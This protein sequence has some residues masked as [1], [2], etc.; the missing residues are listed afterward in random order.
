MAGVEVTAAVEEWRGEPTR[1][2]E[3]VPV[4]VTVD[5][6]SGESIRLRYEDFALRSPSGERF[7]AL[8]PF[9]IDARQA[10]PI[11]YAYPYD[12]FYVAPHLRSFF[13]YMSPYHGHF[14]H[15]RAF[16]HSY[17]PRFVRYELPTADMVQKALPEGVL[18]PGGKVTG[19]LYFDE[20]VED[21]DL[22]EE[23][24]RVTFEADL[25]DAVTAAHVATIEIPLKLG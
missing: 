5:N 1:L 17:H 14:L 8:P 6:G 25:A 18:E 12:G 23:L 22:V 10:E 2:T 15:D 24:E 7:V 9:D 13:P 4:L 20:D 11:R 3:V 16:F 19:F 21:E